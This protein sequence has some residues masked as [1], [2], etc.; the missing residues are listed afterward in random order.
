MS[1][2]LGNAPIFTK[3]N[4]PKYMFLFS[5]NVTA[6]INFALSLIIYFVFVVAAG[7]PVIASDCNPIKRIIEETGSGI[8]YGSND[9]EELS[10]ILNTIADDPTTM[11]K[12]TQSRQWIE[13]KYNWAVDAENLIKLY[14]RLN[15]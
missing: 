6:L 5:M 9:I 11:E 4:V 8:I 3:M 12:Y 7:L 2:L 14:N 10:Y 13:S 1:S 15:E